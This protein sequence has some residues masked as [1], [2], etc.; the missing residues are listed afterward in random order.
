MTIETVGLTST[1]INQLRYDSDNKTLE[2]QFVKGGSE[3]LRNISK[4]DFKAFRSA[5]SAGVHYN[6]RY[7]SR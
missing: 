7:R 2:I 1:C 4:E 6:Q 5:P 3:T